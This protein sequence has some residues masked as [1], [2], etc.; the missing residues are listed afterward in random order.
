MLHDVTVV[1]LGGEPETRRRAIQVDA[2][3]GD[4]AVSRA[5][6]I[7]SAD[8]RGFQIVAVM[9]AGQAAPDAAPEGADAEPDAEPEAP[10]KRGP[11]RPRKV[12]EA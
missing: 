1:F 4:D 9:P 11:G 6:V 12:S 5:S 10:V 2:D 3:G 7:A 8:G